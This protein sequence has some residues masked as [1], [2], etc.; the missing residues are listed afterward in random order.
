MSNKESVSK[1]IVKKEAVKREAS[2]KEAV[3][4]AAKQEEP[5]RKETRREVKKEIPASLQLTLPLP[6]GIN[7]QYSTVNGRRVL[8]EAS[9][10]WKHEVAHY[11]QLLEE[12]NVITD[13]IL[14]AFSINHLSF[15]LDF[16]FATPHRRDLDG[17]LKITLD[18]ICASMNLN[19]NRVVDI[20]LIKKIDP[21]KPRLEVT[22]EAI[23]DWQFDTQYVYLGEDS[24][25]DST[26]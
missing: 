19:D 22:M 24:I 3:S 6:P 17:G 26:S 11:I 16:Y 10:K 12:R 23:F 2:K 13:Y 1:E 5:V 4:K 20:H 18:A 21:L 14:H 15:F 9:R 8:S 25:S 7:A